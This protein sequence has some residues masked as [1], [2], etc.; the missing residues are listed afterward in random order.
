MDHLAQYWRNILYFLLHDATEGI[1]LTRIKIS[2]LTQKK[3]VINLR[4]K[5]QLLTFLRHVLDAKSS[6]RYYNAEVLK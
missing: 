4:A 2:D 3:I 6:R 5:T 1:V